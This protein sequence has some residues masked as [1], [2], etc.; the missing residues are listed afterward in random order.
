MMAAEAQANLFKAHADYEAALGS[1]IDL[2][3]QS[4]TD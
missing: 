3:D 2:K 1:P 4:M